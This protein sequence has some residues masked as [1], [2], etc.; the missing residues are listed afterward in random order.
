MI[1][2]IVQEVREARAA[3]AANFD[4]DLGNFLC[5]GQ[6]PHHRRTKG[7][8]PLAH[9]ARPPA[10]PTRRKTAKAPVK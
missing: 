7:Q 9:P 4:C 10:K 5:L 1:D 2:T 6:G 8:A 3:V